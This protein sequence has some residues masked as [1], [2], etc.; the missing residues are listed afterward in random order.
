V[1][2]PTTV[3][4]DLH[5]FINAFESKPPIMADLEIPAI[6]S[7]DVVET[8]RSVYNIMDE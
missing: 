4:N 6:T 2:V 7:A 1:V 3:Y 5:E 8:L